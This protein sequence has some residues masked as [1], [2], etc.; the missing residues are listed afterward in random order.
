MGQ[1]PGR[2]ALLNSV[3]CESGCVLQEHQ[4]GKRRPVTP[5]KFWHGRALALGL[6]K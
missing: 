1:R 3:V 6:A 2:P 5:N 4:G